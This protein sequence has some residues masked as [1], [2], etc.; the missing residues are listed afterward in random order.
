[1]VMLR[2]GAVPP[3]LR[4]RGTTVNRHL[5]P[6]GDGVTPNRPTE[7]TADDGES[8]PWPVGVAGLAYGGDYN[9][10]QLVPHAGTD[11]ELWRSTV[12]LGRHLRATAELRG[13]RVRAKV[14][15]V[16]SYPAWWGTELDSHPSVDV[17]YPDRVL[18]HY[19]ALWQRNVT[20]DL[21]PPAADLTRYDLVVVPTLHLLTDTE[22]TG[23]A[24]APGDFPGSAPFAAG[25]GLAAAGAF[26]TAPVPLPGAPAPA[27][28]EAPA[29]LAA[30]LPA[31]PPPEGAEG[32]GTAGAL[33]P[34]NMR[35]TAP[36]SA[37]GHG[38]GQ[39]RRRNVPCRTSM[40]SR[41]TPALHRSPP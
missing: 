26:L 15:I 17:T 36:G 2:R 11:T 31:P 4:R 12:E 7:P 34:M 32:P 8:R 33:I 29:E 37:H 6:G 18:A 39:V 19:R 16:F 30:P 40:R 1:M 35:R 14:A 25:L 28:F 23:I 22:A 3:S 41:S 5:T 13:S 20:V 24:A 21:V 27:A 9:P 38:W 10:D